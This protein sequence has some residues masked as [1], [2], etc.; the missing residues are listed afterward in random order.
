MKLVNCTF[1]ELL[2]LRYERFQRFV[3]ECKYTKYLIEM[4]HIVVSLDL[5]ICKNHIKIAKKKN[6]KC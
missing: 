5:C 3:S 1:F 6:R 2:E 4:R